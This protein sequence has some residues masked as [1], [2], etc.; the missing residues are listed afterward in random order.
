MIKKDELLYLLKQ[1][2]DT[3]EKAMPIYTRHL[4]DVLFLAQLKKENREKMRE[5][6]ELL[7]EQ[8]GKHKEL[9]DDLIKT[10]TE[11]KQDVY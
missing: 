2:L 3:E 10:V 7:N 9:F 11:S 5:I 1:C 8:S 6:L 4:N